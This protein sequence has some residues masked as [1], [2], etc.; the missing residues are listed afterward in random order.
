MDLFRE[1]I[2]LLFAG[3][4]YLVAL[5]WADDAG[6][7]KAAARGDPGYANKL[8]VVVSAAFVVS[9]GFR[10]AERVG[11]VAGEASPFEGVALWAAALAWA[12]LPA[13]GIRFDLVAGALALLLTHQLVRAARPPHGSAPGRPDASGVPAVPQGPLPSVPDV[14]RGAEGPVE[15][16]TGH[17]V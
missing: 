7:F 15:L 14:E 6:I 12:L 16:R 8:M 13:H 4:G 1:R 10:Y 3:L 5:G 11:R 9:L 17:L 2:T